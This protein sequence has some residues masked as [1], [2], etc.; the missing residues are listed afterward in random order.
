MIQLPHAT[1]AR[2]KNHRRLRC[3][4]PNHST[5]AA[6]RYN[7]RGPASTL[8][9]PVLPF[10]LL[11]PSSSFFLRLSSL[12]LFRAPP[13]RRQPLLQVPR[14]LRSVRAP[15]PAHARGTQDIEVFVR[16]KCKRCD[17]RRLNEYFHVRQHASFQSRGVVRNAK[18]PVTLTVLCLVECRPAARTTPTTPPPCRPRHHP[19]VVATA[20][21]I[22]A[23]A[24]AAVGT[25]SGPAAGRGSPSGR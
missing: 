2:F 14:G 4:Q 8:D 18:E 19:P 3:H 22:P 17:R 1:R 13:Y 6:T 24:A 25:R 5:A 9:F 21:M 10:L 7:H 15:E 23:Q 12:L 16:L 20:L 11:F